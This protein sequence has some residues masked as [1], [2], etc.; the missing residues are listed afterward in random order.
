MPCYELSKWPSYKSVKSTGLSDQY[1]L[2]M[3]ADKHI[4]FKSVKSTGLSDQYNLGM[5][6][7]KHILYKS[8][9]STGLS[10]QLLG[11]SC[12]LGLP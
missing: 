4:L 10:D 12:L 6:A 1:N 2:G 8:V 3:T 7:G 9:M 5:T 11:K